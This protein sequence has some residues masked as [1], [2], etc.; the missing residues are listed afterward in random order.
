M[1]MRL[2]IK[3]RQALLCFAVISRAFSCLSED[4]GVMYL[5]IFV[6]NELKDER[7]RVSKHLG[8]A[9]VLCVCVDRSSNSSQSVKASCVFW[10]V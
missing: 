1:G 7:R 10:F 5:S 4:K 8:E 2:E 3:R 6:P 9:I